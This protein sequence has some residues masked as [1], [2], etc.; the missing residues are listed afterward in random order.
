MTQKERNESVKSINE[1][2]MTI[3][4]N[5]RHYTQAN[6]EISNFKVNFNEIN[7]LFLEFIKKL[8]R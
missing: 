2:D 6:V 5:I 3:G 4:E 8:K 7:K 1:L